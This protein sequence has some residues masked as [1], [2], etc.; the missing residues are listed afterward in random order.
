MASGLRDPL[1][2]SLRC[3]ESVRLMNEG[4]SEWV[5]AAGGRVTARA[6]KEEVAV[7]SDGLRCHYLSSAVLCYF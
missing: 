5:G 4:R 3:L 2:P 1:P 7:S 6:V